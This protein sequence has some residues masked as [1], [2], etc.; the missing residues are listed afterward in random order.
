VSFSRGQRR[1]PVDAWVRRGVLLGA[2]AFIV[3][4]VGSAIVVAPLRPLHFFQALIYVAIVLL[5]RRG[6]VW[7]LGAGVA[8]PL[9]WNVSE[10]FGPHLPQDGAAAFLTLLRT[11]QA[12]RVDTMMVTLGWIAH[13]VLIA[14]CLVA[15]ARRRHEARAWARFAGGAVVSLAYFALIV[16]TLLPH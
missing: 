2:A 4:L 10:F 9:F 7:G 8:V 5:V 6:S 1:A 12:Q 16:A 15:F 13:D 11:G 14:C 3:A